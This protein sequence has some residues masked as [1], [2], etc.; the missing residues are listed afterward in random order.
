MRVLNPMTDMIGSTS[1][2]GVTI[3]ASYTQLSL[4]FGDADFFNSLYI[5]DDRVNYEWM[6][7]TEDERPFRIYD[8]KEGKF[9]DQKVIEWHIGS[10][11]LYTS[12]IAK[13]EVVEELM[14]R[15][16]DHSPN[17]QTFGQEIRKTG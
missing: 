12:L 11:D 5:G 4:A 6:C 17:D 7:F 10:Q 8:W 16:S 2:H 1:Y 14:A 3:K 15:L 13:D 9:N